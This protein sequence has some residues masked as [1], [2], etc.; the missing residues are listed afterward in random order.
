MLDEEALVAE[1][2]RLALFEDDAALFVD[3]VWL[4]LE[5]CA[6][7]RVLLVLLLEFRLSVLLAASDAELTELVF[8]EPSRLDVLELFF[9]TLEFDVLS[10]WL[11]W[12]R[13]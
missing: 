1:A 3:A 9:W 13:R 10:S 2:F 8:R 6:L 4:A 5:D 11:F 7:F 12:P